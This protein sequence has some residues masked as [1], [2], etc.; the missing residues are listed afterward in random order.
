MVPFAK[1]VIDMGGDK[2]GKPQTSVVLD[3]D[4]PKEATAP[5]ISKEQKKWNGSLLRRTMMRVG[6]QGVP[7]QPKPGGPIVNAIPDKLVR[8]E[9]F[10]ATPAD[11][12]TPER[13]ADARRKAYKR[14]LDWAIARNKVEARGSMGSMMSGCSTRSTTRRVLSPPIPTQMGKN[15][16]DNTRTGFFN[17]TPNNRTKA[18]TVRVVTSAKHL[19]TPGRVMQRTV[20]PVLGQ[21]TEQTRCL[22]IGTLFRLALLSGP[23]ALVRS[24]RPLEPRPKSTPSPAGIKWPHAQQ[25]TL[26][27]QA[28][29]GPDRSAEAA[30]PASFKTIAEGD[31]CDR[32]WVMPLSKSSIRAIGVS[33]TTYA[34]L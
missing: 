1:R 31:S 28:R 15:R 19:E 9:F 26:L 18:R 23:D 5:I 2:H 21:Q 22:G 30:A 33:Y 8:A 14:A 16:T 24:C 32:K 27:R 25:I 6:A 13:K 12:D 7:Q 11:G 3:W 4:P 34:R 29:P 17:R 20:E 10:A